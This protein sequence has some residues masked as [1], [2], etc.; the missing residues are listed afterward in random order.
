MSPRPRCRCSMALRPGRHPT[1]A[2]DTRGRDTRDGAARC[3]PAC[4]R[5]RIRHR[6]GLPRPAE[7]GRRDSTVRDACPVSVVVYRRAGT[8]G[9]S[10]CVARSECPRHNADCSRRA[11][12]EYVRSSSVSGKPRTGAVAGGPGQ[13]RRHHG[14]KKKDR[15]AGGFPYVPLAPHNPNGPIAT[16]AAVHLLAAIPNCYMLELVGSPDD[17]DLH[18][19]MARPAL[20]PRDGSIR[21]PDA[22]G[23]GLEFISGCDKAMPYQPFE[24]WR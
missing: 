4:G 21:V 22:P 3:R 16:A 11:A 2:R 20:R 9:G 14:S 24:G 23:L 8:A 7:R 18:E 10:A 5:R 1:R 19:R 12:F 13:L 17:L 6:R 15:R